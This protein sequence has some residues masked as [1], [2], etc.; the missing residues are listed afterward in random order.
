MKNLQRDIV[1]I[2]DSN[3]VK[4]AT[5]E[6]DSFGKIL[7][8]IGNSGWAITDINYIALINLFRYRSYYYDDETEL[9]Y[10]NSRY[11]KPDNIISANKDIIYTNLYS[12]CSNNY[13]NFQ[14]NIGN[15][16]SNII[17][18]YS[19]DYTYNVIKIVSSYYKINIY[20]DNKIFTSQINNNAM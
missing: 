1:G 17:P 15:F 3:N 12:Y 4:I 5:Y 10:I 9:Y 11:Y 16:I 6:Y 2:R 7:S 18:V 19:Y 8:I 14:D 13:I 20:A